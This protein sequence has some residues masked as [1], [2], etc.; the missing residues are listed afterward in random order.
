M[1]PPCRVTTRQPL[2]C[3]RPE[4]ERG[5]D[6]GGQEG[7][8]SDQSPVREDIPALASSVLSASSLCGNLFE[9]HSPTDPPEEGGGGRG[10][11]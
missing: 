4:A 9:V 3:S 11:T 7:E 6:D 8:E 1:R 2:L 10:C 5:E